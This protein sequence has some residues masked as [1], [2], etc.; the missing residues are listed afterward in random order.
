MATRWGPPLPML[1]Q[2]ATVGVATLVVGGRAAGAPLVLDAPYSSFEAGLVPRFIES[3]DVNGDGAAD[4][5]VGSDAS[6]DVSILLGVGDG[7]FLA[8]QTFALTQP[9]RGFELGDVTGDGHLDI[10]ACDWTG[11]SIVLLPGRGDGSF[12]APF[13]VPAGPTPAA[14]GAGD[15]DEDGRNDLVVCNAFANTVSVLLAVDGGSFAL[16]VAYPGHDG[17][18]ELAIADLSGDGHLDIVVAE[19]AAGQLAVQIGLGDGTLGPK[20]AWHLGCSPYLVAVGDVDA[21]GILDLATIGIASFAHRALLLLGTGAGSYVGSEQVLPLTESITSLRLGDLSGDGRPDLALDGAVLPGLGDGSFGPPMSPPALLDPEGVVELF[22]DGDARLDLAIAD[23]GTGEVA[24]FL[25]RDDGKLAGGVEIGLGAPVCAAAATDLTGDGRIDVAVAC[26]PNDDES[27]CERDCNTAPSKLALLAGTPTGGFVQFDFGT[28]DNGCASEDPG[29]ACWGPW[30]WDLRP[31]EGF[32]IGDLD[33]D[34]RPDVVVTNSRSGKL[35][36]FLSQAP[37]PLVRRPNLSSGGVWPVDVVARDLNGD[38]HL[39]LAVANAASGSLAIFA[40]HGDASFDLPI[41]V[42]ADSMPGSVAAGDW[43]EDGDVDLAVAN[44]GSQILSIY[45]ADAPGSFSPAASLAMDSERIALE[46]ADLDQDG[47]TD[48]VAAQ[49]GTASIFYGDGTGGFETR[50]NL[51][52]GRE[53]RALALADVDGDGR[54]DLL[55]G[56]SPVYLTVVPATGARSYGPRRTFGVGIDPRSVTASDLDGDGDADVLVGCG[57]SLVILWN[58]TRTTPIAIRD[59]AASAS[60]DRVLLS[61]V[62][63]SELGHRIERVALQRAETRLGPYRDRD[64]AIEDVGGRMFC[65]DRLEAAHASLWYRV[66][67]CERDGQE[68]VAGPIEVRVALASLPVTALRPPVESA[69]GVRI[70]FTLAPNAPPARLTIH[71]V[72]GREVWSRQ[73]EWL[74]AGDQVRTWDT[75]DAKG[76]PVGRSVYFVSLRTGPWVATE[77]FLLLRRPA[78]GL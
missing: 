66:L 18:W 6:G 2:L 45:L 52:V 36:V 22:A 39:D 68:H 19:M 72:R 13:E 46:A 15:L 31:Q 75:R 34:G 54:L 8:P 12:D 4:L 51:V 64:V 1:R 47:H 9:L 37:G 61:W 29:A 23:A 43:D 63:E 16:P 50:M 14:V 67:V 55:V 71:D 69:G 49:S 5:V 21:D 62:V 38:G 44:Q 56:S 70:S 59:L 11:Q 10:F 26:A 57:G 73:E 60:M 41:E 27:S 58:R 24:V 48:L 20:T 65:E 74:P 3:G 77:K 17:P 33:E 78:G 7:T 76:R 32:D 35:D 25:G 30:G 40:G 28:S 42:D 53:V